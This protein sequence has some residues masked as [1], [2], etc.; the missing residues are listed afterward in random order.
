MGKISEIIGK[1][2]AN[3]KG[4]VTVEV[5]SGRQQR[6]KTPY[7]QTRAV[8]SESGGEIHRDEVPLIYQHYVQQY[9]EKVRGVPPPKPVSP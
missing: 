2:S 8:H 9:F 4:E 3:V 6:L 1:R 7:S 5:S